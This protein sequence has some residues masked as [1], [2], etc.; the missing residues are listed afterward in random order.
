LWIIAWLGC[1]S[2][3]AASKVLNEAATAAAAAAAAAGVTL[4]LLFTAR[5]HG[6][7]NNSTPAS[8]LMDHLNPSQSRRAG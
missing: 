5:Q 1:A 8:H 2:R 3:S 4:H 6:S 7:M